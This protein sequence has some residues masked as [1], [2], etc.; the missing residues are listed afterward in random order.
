LEKKRKEI[1]SMYE[2]TTQRKKT[3][4]I[5]ISEVFKALVS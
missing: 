1:Q 2:H 4:G 5:E 3:L